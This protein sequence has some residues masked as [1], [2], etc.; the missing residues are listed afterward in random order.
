MEGTQVSKKGV[1]K[2]GFHDVSRCVL[3][4]VSCQDTH[5]ID[6]VAFSAA[7]CLLLS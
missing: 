5:L 6:R 1:F 7:S 2:G 3:C 4:S